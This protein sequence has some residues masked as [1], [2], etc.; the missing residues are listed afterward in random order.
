MEENVTIYIKYKDIHDVAKNTTK[1]LGMLGLTTNQLIEMNKCDFNNTILMMHGLM[2]VNV[3]S[4]NNNPICVIGM[5]FSYVVNLMIILMIVAFSI[6]FIII[7]YNAFLITI[8]ERQKEYAVL[9][10]IG[11]TE[12][13]DT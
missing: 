13:T 3:S 5:N 12:R 6:L 2:D 10:S 11:G 4:V 1:I 7:L 8:D 9:N